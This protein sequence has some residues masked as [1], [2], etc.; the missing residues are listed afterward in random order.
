MNEIR[1]IN[2]SVSAQ[3]IQSHAPST[4]PPAPSAQ[5]SSDSVE[6]SFQAQVAGKMA[7]IPDVRSDLVARVKA[8]IANGTYDTPEKMDQALNALLKEL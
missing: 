5:E 7:G 2:P 6:I 4:Q 3:R 8:E 1:G